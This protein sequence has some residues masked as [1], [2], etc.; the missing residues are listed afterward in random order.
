M[1]VKA[2][3]LY[4]YEKWSAGKACLSSNLISI[5]SE[6]PELLKITITTFPIAAI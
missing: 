1:S 2:D 3:I 6:P 5:L 4:Y